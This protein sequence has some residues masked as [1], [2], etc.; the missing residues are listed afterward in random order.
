[1]VSLH[2]Q[3]VILSALLAKALR[4]F[5]RALRAIPNSPSL[6]VVRFIE[7]MTLWAMSFLSVQCRETDR[8][9]QGILLRR[10]DTHVC[11]IHACAVTARVPYQSRSYLPVFRVIS[12]SVG[13]AIDPAKIERAVAVP[14]ERGLPH[15]ALPHGFPF[16]IEALG[17]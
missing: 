15:M 16:T 6:A 17:L 9:F 3:N 11:G 13:A 10:D 12:D 2:R 5:I 8:V 7:R 14:V 1:M 4:L